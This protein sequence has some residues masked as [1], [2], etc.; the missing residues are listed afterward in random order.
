MIDW[1]ESKCVLLFRKNSLTPCRIRVG[2]QS[3]EKKKKTTTK[4]FFESCQIN[5][6]SILLKLIE[7]QLPFKK[8]YIYIYIYILDQSVLYI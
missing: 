4:T 8:E 2:T 6:F 1:I 7:D 3:L 5:I